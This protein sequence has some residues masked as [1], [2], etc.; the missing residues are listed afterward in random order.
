MTSYVVASLECGYAFCLAFCHSTDK[1]CYAQIISGYVPGQRFQ[2]VSWST[3]SIPT[4]FYW[5]ILFCTLL[6]TSFIRCSFEQ[7][8]GSSLLA[9]EIYQKI[10]IFC[11]SS[12]FLGTFF[13][14]P[15][16]LNATIF[17]LD[18][19]LLKVTSA[20]KLFLAVK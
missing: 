11:F 20:T 2:L 4:K 3:S 15:W 10:T 14:H 9:W 8:E 1:K 5:F 16:C 13:G 17:I 18:A 19:T 7:T 12:S 6:T